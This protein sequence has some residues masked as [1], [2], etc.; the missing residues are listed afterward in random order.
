MNAK[1]VTCHFNQDLSWLQKIKYPTV[2]YSKTIKGEK[3]IDFNKAL[4]HP[5]YLKFIIDNWSN[6]PDYTIF[7]HGHESSYHQSR[8]MVDI[9]NSLS[10]D[11]L[12]INLNDSHMRKVMDK[13]DEHWPWLYNCW[14]GLFKPY[15]F[16]LPSKLGF[17]CCAQF[18]VH[19]SLILSNPLEYYEHAYN[20]CKKTKLRNSISSRIFEYT[21]W[22]I[23]TKQP[24]ISEK[25]F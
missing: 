19:K 24:I 10:F 17:P 1:V 16:E 5:V 25:N 4:E 3:F 7:I 8:L 6:L 9:I 13:N 22:Y 23:F 2:V 11:K 21:W 18:A 14:K 15:G 12:M 20:W